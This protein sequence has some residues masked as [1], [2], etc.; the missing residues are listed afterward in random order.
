MLH[1]MM[2]ELIDKPA[3]ELEVL[4]RKIIRGSMEANIA[5][6]PEQKVGLRS[7]M[8]T[9]DHGFVE[10]VRHAKEYLHQKLS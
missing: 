5:Q 2:P 8:E 7:A 6:A 4:I 1:G 3:N 10:N 9:L